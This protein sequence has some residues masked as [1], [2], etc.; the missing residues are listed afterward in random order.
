MFVIISRAQ[1]NFCDVAKAAL[2]NKGYSYTEY[3]IESASSKWVLS[4]M[5]LAELNTVPQIFDGKGKHIGGYT[6]LLK[7]LGGD[8]DGE[9]NVG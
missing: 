3:S 9:S 5:R 2:K 1:C 7:Y 6:E 4:L 8:I